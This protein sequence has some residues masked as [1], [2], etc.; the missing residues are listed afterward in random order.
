MNAEQH[1]RALLQQIAHR[2]MLDRGLLPDYSPAVL[3]EV[4]ALAGTEAAAASAGDPPSDAP[5]FGDRPAGDPPA[6][7][8][9]D[10]PDPETAAMS[11]LRHLLWCSIDN[12]DSRDLDQLTVAEALPD[13]RVRVL[14]AIA[15]VDALVTKGSATDGHAGHNTTSVYT[16]AKI[17]SMLPEELS[18]DRTSL[19]PREVRP[20]MVVEMVVAPDGTLEG[21]DVYPGLVLNHAKLAYD[22]VAAW[23]EDEA[24]APQAL[25]AVPGLAENLRL[26]DKAAQRLKVLRHAQGALELRTIEAKPVFDGDSISELKESEQNRAKDIIED[27]MIAVNGVTARFLSARGYPSIRRVVRTPQRWERIVELAAEHGATLPGSPDAEALEDFL[28]AFHARDPIR[29]PDLSL[30]IVKLLGPGEYT[31]TRPDD[32]SPRHFGLAVKD[33]GHSTAPNRRYADLLTQRLLK[34]ALDGEPSP[35]DV[36]EL[37]RLADHCTKQENAANKVER[38]VGKSAA[39]LLLASRLGEEF[40]AIVTG[41]APK[42]TWVRLLKVPVEGRLSEGFEGVDVGQRLR[43]KLIS[44]DVWRGFIDFRRVRGTHSA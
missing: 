12:D 31:A 18:T 28:V 27:F 6:P 35:Y 14:V 36:D 39:T 24:P 22:S 5:A 42:G 44:V 38:Q 30:A 13:D 17:F 9:T 1:D 41:A 25:G 20:A 33:Y 19:N 34:A 10:D 4:Q 26:Q 11:D 3:A 40:E 32:P 2:A 37:D 8:A 7:L 43:V 15:D 29:F 16:A 23:L 21:S